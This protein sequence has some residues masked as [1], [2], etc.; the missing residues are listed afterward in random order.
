MEGFIRT[1]FHGHKMR[2]YE[3][4][5]KELCAVKFCIQVLFGQIEIIFS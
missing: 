5:G 3:G 4:M 2:L 1:T